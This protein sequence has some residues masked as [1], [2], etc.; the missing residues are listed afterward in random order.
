MQAGGAAAHK[1]TPPIW[2]KAQGWDGAGGNAFSLSDSKEGRRKNSSLASSASYPI[3]FTDP[4]HGLAEGGDSTPFSKMPSPI[5]RAERGDSDHQHHHTGW[6]RAEKRASVV[7]PRCEEL[8][9]TCSS[10]TEMMVAVAKMAVNSRLCISD[11][12][13]QPHKRDGREHQTHPPKPTRRVSDVG[14]AFK[15]IRSITD[16]SHDVII[17]E[18]SGKKKKKEKRKNKE[19]E[20]NKEKKS[21]RSSRRRSETEEHDNGKIKKHKEANGM[22][23][24]SPREHPFKKGGGGGGHVEVEEGA[25]VVDGTKEKGKEKEES[26]RHAGEDTKEWTTMEERVEWLEGLVRRMSAEQEEMKRQHHEA[27]SKL[28]QEHE[29]AVQQ[30]ILQMKQLWEQFIEPKRVVSSRLLAQRFGSPHHL[31]SEG[32]S[33]ALQSSANVL[34]LDEDV[35]PKQRSFEKED[36]GEEEQPATGILR[37]TLYR[38]EA[39]PRSRSFREQMMKG[40]EA[41]GGIL[42]SI[43]SRFMSPVKRPDANN[44]PSRLSHKHR[45]DSWW[46]KRPASGN[47]DQGGG[48]RRRRSGDPDIF[49]EGRSSVSSNSSISSDGEASSREGRG[50]GIHHKIQ[51]PRARSFSMPHQSPLALSSVRQEATKRPRN[52][53]LWAFTPSG[54]KAH[55]CA[56]AQ[57]S[58]CVCACECDVNSQLPCSPPQIRQRQS[59]DQS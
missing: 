12:R 4:T 23:G 27:I 40:N 8:S 56:Y 41:K 55:S 32:L 20:K 36:D 18:R 24:Y 10:T 59:H 14:S 19:K 15:T 16:F 49:K 44:S 47:S 42:R 53:S 51:Y 37:N 33:L 17:T 26:A 38:I 45:S 29:T 6:K 28:Q 3:F 22:V 46:V 11:S 48:G 9:S 57:A 30:L 50:S 58:A 1:G 52:K 43:S 13:R 21:S 54:E 35:S 2:V 7:G 25:G 34:P 39:R 31:S 5:R